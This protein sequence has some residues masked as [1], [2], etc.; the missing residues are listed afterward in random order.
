MKVE[1]LTPRSGLCCCHPRKTTTQ[2]FEV[3]SAILC[4][5]PTRVLQDRALSGL[6]LA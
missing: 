3:S 6:L 5:N 2:A 4:T 1:T